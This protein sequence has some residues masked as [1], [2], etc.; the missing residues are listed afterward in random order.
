MFCKSTCDARNPATDSVK[1]DTSAI[2]R[3]R[4]AAERAERERVALH[5]RAEEERRLQ[6]QAERA[7][8][9]QEQQLRL[10]EERERIRREEERERLEQEERA[11]HEQE[12]KLRLEHEEQ[13]RREEMERQQKEVKQRR[14]TLAQFYARHGF[15]GINEPRRSGCAVLRSATTYPLHCAVELGDERIVSM[16]LKEGASTLQ[17]DSSGKTA[18][19]VAQKKNKGSSHEG[20]LRLLGAPAGRPQ[21][22]GA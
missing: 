2:E 14:E 1:V 19:Q 18:A 17:K 9:E 13:A 3:Q 12:E 5:E 8:L 7:R 4:Q 22:G 10:E 11:R 20:V 15:T 21:A 16:L 6:E